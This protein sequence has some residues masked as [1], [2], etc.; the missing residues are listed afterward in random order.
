[1]DQSIELD[2][3]RGGLVTIL[4]ELFET[5]RRYIL[6]QNENLWATLAHI[7]ADT[8]SET[9]AHG[10]ATIAGQVSH[11]DFLIDAVL[12]H[13]GEDLDWEAA[14]NVGAVTDEE[15]ADLVRR[16][17]ARYDELKAYASTHADWDQMMIG[18]AFALVA[19]IAYHLGQI[20]EALGVIRA[21]R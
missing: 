7:D 5:D 13:F 8:A 16:L 11:I 15:W 14:W 20:R 1:M 19:H 4:E 10:L 17:R 2:A 21:V 6:D 9:F 18:G 3:F 12:N